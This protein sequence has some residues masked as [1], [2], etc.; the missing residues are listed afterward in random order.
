MLH[1]VTRLGMDAEILTRALGGIWRGHT[2][3]AP[4]PV[5]QPERRRDQQ[6][7]SL[8]MEG[9]RL[10]SFCH[11]TGCTF[12]DI[13][14]AAGLPPGAVMNDAAAQRE[15]NKIQAENIARR[16][17][18]AKALW[19]DATTTPIYG[20]LSETYL[21]GRGITCA[22]PDSLRFQPKGWHATGHYL[23]MMLARVDGA[24]GFAV[25]R[26]Y[27][28]ADGKGKAAVAPAKAMLGPCAGGA[29]RMSGGEG[30]LV[31]CEGIETGLS[32]LCGLLRTAATVWAALSTSGMRS[33]HLP[34][35]PGRLTIAADG[36]QPGRDA[37]YALA[38]RAE[39]L[40]WRVSLLPAPNGRDW[41]DILFLSVGKE[42]T[43]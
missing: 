10:L 38:S 27:L 9:G 11:K 29:V 36:D 17:N 13:A 6:G 19:H 8:R 32:L 26:T 21:R 7:L 41:N 39:A 35:K 23:P 24:A 15:A 16:E 18:Q 37:A 14:T 33:L 5:C 28:R 12:R 30:P 43:Q 1:K 25:H 3:N 20:T 42:L 4:C 22:L 2:G 40:G 34:P 31:V